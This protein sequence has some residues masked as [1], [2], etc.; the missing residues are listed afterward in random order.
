MLKKLRSSAGAQAGFTVA[1][2]VIAIL[3]LI[4]L[5]T[6][7]I[8]QRQELLSAQRDDA[9]KTAINAM[10]YDLTEV[11][12][13]QNKYYPD[14]ISRSNLTAMDPTL[15]TDPDGY[16]LSGDACKSGDNAADSSF[17]NY[18]YQA[19][20]CNSSGQCQAFT[21]AADMETE[22]AYTKNSPKR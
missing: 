18:H 9:R 21:M 16:T 11:F 13:A 15:F 5:T 22:T 10:Y 7:F 2:L 3:I 4:I 12:Y 19:S 6:F 1:E 8:I 20:D 14:T 17:C